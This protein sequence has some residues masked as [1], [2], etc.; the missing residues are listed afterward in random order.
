M[1]VCLTPQLQTKSKHI[2][3]GQN[4]LLVIPFLCGVAMRANWHSKSRA[5]EQL[6]H[7]RASPLPSPVLPAQPLEPM[8]RDAGVV[9]G[10]LGAAVPEVV[11][12]GFEVGALVGQIVAA[13]LQQH[14]RPGPTELRLVAGKPHDVVAGLASELR[15]LPGPRHDRGRA[16]SRFLGDRHRHIAMFAFAVHDLEGNAS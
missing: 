5:F 1:S 6:Q 10:V 14:V 13:G 8:S 12:H 9:G 11:L 4:E 15:H 7:A 16:S 3:P 2:A